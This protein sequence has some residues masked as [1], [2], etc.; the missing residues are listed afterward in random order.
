[1]LTFRFAPSALDRV[2]T[3]AAFSRVPMVEVNG[4]RHQLKEGMGRIVL[5]SGLQTIRWVQPGS[6]ITHGEGSLWWLD[7]RQG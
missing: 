3:Y 2:Y 1:M 4:S 7:Q 5:P 6:R